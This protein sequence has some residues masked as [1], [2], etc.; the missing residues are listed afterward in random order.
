MRI[1][2]LASFA[3]AAT[4]F[5]ASPALAQE[6]APAP[7]APPQEAPQDAAQVQ[8]VSGELVKVDSEK[9][10]L[11]V[12]MADGAE[13]TIAFNDQTEISGDKKGE[14]GLATAEGAKVIVHYTTSGETKTATKVEVQP[15]EAK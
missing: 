11:S 13:W 2:R 3:F 8:T 12:R 10:T 14:Q 5:V 15:A 4:L 6:P 1:T 9:K 7:A